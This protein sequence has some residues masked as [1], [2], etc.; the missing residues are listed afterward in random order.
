M[1]AAWASVVF[2]LWQ[3]NNQAAAQLMK[4]LYK[5]MLTGFYYVE[6]F[7]DS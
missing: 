6:C 5:Q 3:L 1:Y 4:E 2:S 7:P